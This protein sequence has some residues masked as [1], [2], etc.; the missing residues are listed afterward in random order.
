MILG[1]HRDI[2]LIPIRLKKIQIISKMQNEKVSK[3]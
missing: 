2:M 3:K 1:I